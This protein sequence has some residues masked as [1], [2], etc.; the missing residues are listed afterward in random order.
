MRESIE[1]E[2]RGANSLERKSQQDSVLGR[3]MTKDSKFD[4]GSWPLQT[5]AIDS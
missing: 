4:Q 1:R 2:G 5:R 3:K